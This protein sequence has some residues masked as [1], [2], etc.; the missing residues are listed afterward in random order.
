MELLILMFASFKN[1]TPKFSFKYYGNNVNRF[2]I[3]RDGEIK[4]F[5]EKKYFGNIYHYVYGESFP[6]YEMV[7]NNDFIAVNWYFRM[8][9]D[10]T[11][12]ISKITSVI[13]SGG[14]ISLYYENIPTDKEES[15]LTSTIQFVIHCGKTLEDEILTQIITPPQWITSDTLAE[16]EPIE[17][18][19]FRNKW[20]Q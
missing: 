18:H 19:H 3:S 15:P 10:G 8:L 17:K 4:I 9:H 12:P 14:K 7:D 6:E 11:T 20:T 2:E 1:A 5:G 16:F 13:H